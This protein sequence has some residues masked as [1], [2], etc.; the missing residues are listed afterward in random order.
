M[1]LPMLLPGPLLPLLNWCVCLPNVLLRQVQLVPF[2]AHVLNKSRK[3]ILLCLVPPFFLP[4][5]GLNSTNVFL[6]PRFGAYMRGVALGTIE[7]VF[8]ANNLRRACNQPL[9]H[10]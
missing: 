4:Q 7:E 5:L 3:Q 1:R 9:N 2:P 8:V 6:S 10:I